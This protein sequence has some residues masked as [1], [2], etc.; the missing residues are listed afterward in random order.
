MKTK[1]YVAFVRNIE[2]KKFEIIESE[3]ANKTDFYKDLKANG[4]KVRVITTPEKFDEECEKWERNAAFEKSVRKLNRESDE[5]IAAK[6]NMTYK[7][8]RKW[9]KEL[10]L[11]LKVYDNTNY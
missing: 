10:N 6:M 9:Q 7:E 5:R 4:Y 8:Y 1:K 2:T 3:Y 11:I